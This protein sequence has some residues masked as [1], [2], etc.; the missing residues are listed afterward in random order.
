MTVVSTKPQQL[1]LQILPEIFIILCIKALALQRYHPYPQ[2]IVA[3]GRWRRLHHR[4]P[5]PLHG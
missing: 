2:S 1:L 5:L 3:D 4:H